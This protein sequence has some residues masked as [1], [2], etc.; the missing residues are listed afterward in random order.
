[1]RFLSLF[2]G[3]E[4]AS[5]AWLPLG[6]E[7]V[8]H[9]EI[10]PFPSA[11]LANHYPGV[12]NLGDVTKITEEQIAALGRIDLVVGGFPCQDVSIAGQRKGL[13]HAGE[14]TRSGLFFDAMRLVRIA[15]ERCGLRWLVLENVPGLFSS[16]AG[17]DF[18]AV[19]GEM[20]GA[21]LD[22]PFGGWEAAGVALGQ[23]GL[24]EWRVLDAQFFGLAQRRRRVFLVADFGDWRGRAPV[25]LEPEGLRW[26]PAPRRQARE[27]AAPSPDAGAPAGGDLVAYGGNR[28]GGSIDIATAVRAK[29]GTGHG[30]FESETFI[31]GSM[32]A[33]GGTERKHGHGWGQRDFESGYLVAN[34]LRGQQQPS[35]RED[36]DT[37]V[38]HTLTADGFDASE[39]GTGR[40]PP[41]AVFTLAARGRADGQ[42]LE[43]RDDGLA[44]AILTPSGG[45]AGIGVGAVAF[46]AVQITHPENRANP[47]PGDPAPSLASSSQPMIA[48]A[49]ET[50]ATLVG[51]SSRGGGQ[52]NSPGFNADQQLLAFT[53]NDDGADEEIAST[54]RA[55]GH[56]RSHANAG[57]M[58][59]VA[60]PIQNATR[61]KDQNGLGVGDEDEPMFTLDQGSQHAVAF[62][63]QAGALR[64]NPA[65][66]PDGVGVQEHIAYTVEARA[67][68]QAVAW[69]ITPSQSN[70]DFNA[71]PSERA[72]A[73]TPSGNR[74]SARGGD[75]IAGE[76]STNQH[77]LQ[78]SAV[79]RLTPTE[80]C[81]LQGFP[82][83]YLDIEFRGKPAADGPK[84]KAL[85]N[86]FATPV[87][88][89]IGERIAAAR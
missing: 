83:D 38:A 54:L 41:L 10:E 23:D 81:R 18:A 55:G 67:E 42:Q 37:Y 69:N 53:L 2:S 12:P 20:A 25:L 19:V 34:T 24:V 68:V 39:D 57:V 51:R 13:E 26:D 82:D 47:Q 16:N 59:A 46:D 84:Y 79:R 73:L 88:R 5:V 63:I 36:S 43:F 50:A 7:C 28:T 70:K 64:E 86:A 1:M 62:A 87:V 3:I 45:R 58:P 14:R 33:A 76:P 52:T 65:S 85:G 6:W 72:Q 74:V 80:C 22:P 27:G 11:V 15:R 35:H 89:W 9:A 32:T 66:G 4:G 61:G 48:F 71:R 17:C 77:R 60:I 21:E 8:G 30:D 56:L 44:N 29:G 49:P 78:G 31:A 40:G 75:V